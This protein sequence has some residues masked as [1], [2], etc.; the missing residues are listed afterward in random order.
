MLIVWKEINLKWGL[1]IFY[2]IRLFIN[3]TFLLDKNA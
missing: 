3:S 1:E 2:R